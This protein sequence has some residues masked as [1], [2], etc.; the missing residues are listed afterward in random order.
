M[1]Q[2]TI[3]YLTID[4]LTIIGP[5]FGPERSSQ[6]SGDGAHQCGRWQEPPTDYPSVNKLSIIE[7]SNNRLRHENMK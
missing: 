6:M 1:T 5:T 3:D 4:N 2:L 7:Q